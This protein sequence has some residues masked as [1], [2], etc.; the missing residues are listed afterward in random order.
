MFDIV[1]HQKVIQVLKI[2]KYKCLPSTSNKNLYW[3]KIATILSNDQETENK[4]FEKA[5][6]I[7]CFCN[8]LIY[9][10]AIYLRKR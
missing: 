4:L 9:P 3:E 8:C 10:S 6:D 2:L 7:H 1:K 5:K